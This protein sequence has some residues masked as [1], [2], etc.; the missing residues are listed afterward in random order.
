[1]RV[2]ARITPFWRGTGGHAGA[3]IGGYLKSILEKPW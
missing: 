2:A 3:H 1:M